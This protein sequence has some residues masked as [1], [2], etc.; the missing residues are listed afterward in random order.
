MQVSC[1][2]QSVIQISTDISPKIIATDHLHSFSLIKNFS[3]KQIL[4]ETETIKFHNAI[5]T[6]TM[7]IPKMCK[8]PT[9]KLPWMRCCTHCGIANNL[10]VREAGSHCF[11]RLQL[12]SPG[13][14]IFPAQHW[15]RLLRNRNFSMAKF[16]LSFSTLG[17]FTNNV[18]RPRSVKIPILQNLSSVC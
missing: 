12:T 8:E 2:W 11:D 1:K 5:K 18:A 9:I 16:V 7:V 10:R 13:W 4:T 17:E 3:T 15:Q 14:N 6:S